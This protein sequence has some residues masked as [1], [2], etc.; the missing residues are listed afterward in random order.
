LADV[1]TPRTVTGEAATTGDLDGHYLYLTCIS[2]N[3]CRLNLPVATAGDSFTVVAAS[4]AGNPI[5]I[6]PAVTSQI[7][8]FTDAVGDCIQVAGALG[9]KITL[10]AVSATQWVAI[11]A[12]GTWTDTN[13]CI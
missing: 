9:D 3:P 11:R 2:D 7:L 8:V 10:L 5:E 6:K 12:D 1:D 4:A 13:A